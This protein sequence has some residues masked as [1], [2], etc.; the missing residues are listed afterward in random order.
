MATEH[1]ND[2]LGPGGLSEVVTT[3]TVNG[4]T[5]LVVDGETYPLTK[6]DI[7]H[8]TI[9]ADHAAVA[10]GIALTWTSIVKD[11]TGIT[12]GTDTPFSSHPTKI[13]IPNTVRMI[14]VSAG[15]RYAYVG[16]SP[17]GTYRGFNLAVTIGVTPTATQ[18]LAKV[19]APVLNIGTTSE[20]VLYFTSSLID[21]SGW[22]AGANYIEMK[23]AHDSV[24][25][26]A[27]KGGLTGPTHFK[28]EMYS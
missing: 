17:S 23:S 9:S 12:V 22:A 15:I 5:V 28:V 26:T 3:E 2:R 16:A 13:Y 14:R 7:T 21:V 11:D 19:T 8:L 4:Q 27:I 25:A 6:L 20:G 24:A 1:I 10:D 18:G